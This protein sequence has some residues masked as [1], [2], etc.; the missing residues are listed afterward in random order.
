MTMDPNHRGERPRRPVTNKR[1]L[2]IRGT[3]VSGF[4]EFETTERSGEL[5]VGVVPDERRANPAAPLPDARDSQARSRCKCLGQRRTSTSTERDGDPKDRR[6]QPE[7]WW[8]PGLQRCG[9]R[10]HADGERDGLAG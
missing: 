8:E 4:E 7:E 1:H 6:E 5:M 3:V 2:P 10:E 9:E